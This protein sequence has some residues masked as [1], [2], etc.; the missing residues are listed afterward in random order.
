MLILR[1]NK[2]SCKNNLVSALLH[3]SLHELRCASYLCIGDVVT[4]YYNRWCEKQHRRGTL[5]SGLCWDALR[6]QS[7]WCGAAAMCGNNWFLDEEAL[8]LRLPW[9]V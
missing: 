2:G 9:V 4:C 5:V 1:Q 3:A 8:K 6:S 7:R